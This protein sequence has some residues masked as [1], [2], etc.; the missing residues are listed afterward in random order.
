MKFLKK[1]LGNED[2]KVE[3]NKQVITLKTRVKELEGD[4]EKVLAEKL[5]LKEEVA[6]L[7]IQKKQ[8]TEELKLAHK[9]AEEDIKHLVKLHDE[10]Q[11]V[12]FERKSLE[13]ERKKDEEIAKVKDEYRDKLEKQLAEETKNIRGMYTEI[14]AR[15]PNVN[16]KMTGTM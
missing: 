10:K 1:L 11:V 5:R 16:V 8:E 6:E 9:T 3:L 13:L 7:K 4:H 12:Q 2:V 15:L 14:L